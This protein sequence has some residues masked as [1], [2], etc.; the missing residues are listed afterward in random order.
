MNNTYIYE[1][2][3]DDMF[4]YGNFDYTYVFHEY[5]NYLPKTNIIIKKRLF[6]IYKKFPLYLETIIYN[7]DKHIFEST[8][9]T[10]EIKH[11][12]YLTQSTQIPKIKNEQQTKIK[13]SANFQPNIKKTKII[14]YT[15][16][17][18]PKD[19]SNV[20]DI[21]EE[22]KDNNELQE[23]INNTDIEKLESMISELEDEKKLISDFNSE[24]Q[25][26][27]NNQKMKERLI[28][29]KKR[30]LKNIYEADYNLYLKFV[31]IQYLIECE[32]EYL[33]TTPNSKLTKNELTAKAHIDMNKEFNIPLLF[34]HKFPI[35]EFMDENELLETENAFIIFK[36]LY[37][38]NYEKI[39]DSRK[40][41]GDDVYI[42]DTSEKEIFD[43]LPKKELIDN[44]NKNIQII[45]VNK[46]LEEEIGKSKTPQF[47]ASKPI[48]D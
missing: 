19:T 5:L 45:N 8:E 4:T 25:S 44:F 24:K 14:N 16:N 13:K 43:S 17:E 30:E 27:I 47:Y 15:N 20:K 40:Y 26:E 18:V 38:S 23:I 37:Y 21:S 11:I 10:Y 35:L 39:S 29:D 31:E 46:L 36:Y 28:E 42:H 9:T 2:F 22:F 1:L 6:D 48:E 32:R 33:T 7:Q 41:F 12:S 3:I 34:S